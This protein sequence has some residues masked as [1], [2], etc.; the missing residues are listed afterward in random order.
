MREV[1]VHDPRS[2]GQPHLPAPAV[3]RCH[4]Q[5]EIRRVADD[6]AEPHDGFDD[7][8]AEIGAG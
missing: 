2:G 4:V 8:V 5:L 6:V 3:G 7:D 1:N